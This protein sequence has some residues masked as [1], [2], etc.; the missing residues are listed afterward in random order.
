LL[1][2]QAGGE[3]SKLFKNRH[4]HRPICLLKES[5]FSFGFCCEGINCSSHNESP[6]PSGFGIFN[7]SSG[8]PVKSNG[9]SLYC[10]SDSVPAILARFCHSS[11]TLSQGQSEKQSQTQARPSP[12]SDRHLRRDSIVLWPST[13]DAPV[14]SVTAIWESWSPKGRPSC[15]CRRSIDSV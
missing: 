9:T 7:S 1:R 5:V 11:P 10:E 14:P 2:A 6:K 12:H 13:Y 4:D 8:A 15:P 3:S